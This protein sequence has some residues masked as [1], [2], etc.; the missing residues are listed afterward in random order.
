VSRQTI[1]AEGTAPA[2]GPYSHAVKIPGQ[3]WVSGQIGMTAD[4]E[5]VAGGVEAEARQALANLKTVLEAAGSSLDRVVKAT[6]YLVEMRDFA[7]VNAIYADFF[8]ESPPARVC[9]EVSGLPKGA[10]FE[11]D[12][13]ALS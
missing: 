7:A 3:V 9:V 4:G 1:H 8:G 6:I 10:S 13:V 12:A 5:L 11:V 2:V